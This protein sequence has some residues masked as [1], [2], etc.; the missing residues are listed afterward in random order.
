M[1]AV[2]PIAKRC[3]RAG[4]SLVPVPYTVAPS[5]LT[6][7]LASPSISLVVSRYFARGHLRG[8]TYPPDL[9]QRYKV[10][11]LVFTDSLRQVGTKHL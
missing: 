3:L 11:A 5:R 10:P 1:K 2:T 8:R 6:G 9:L 7:S 4:T